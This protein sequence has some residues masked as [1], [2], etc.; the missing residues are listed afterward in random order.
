[1]VA[2]PL[3]TCLVQLDIE[4]NWDELEIQQ[5]FSLQGFLKFVHVY[6]ALCKM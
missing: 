5:A 6:S 3:I 2:V 1:M 4:L